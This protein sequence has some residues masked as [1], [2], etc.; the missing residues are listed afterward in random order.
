MKQPLIPHM[1]LKQNKKTYSYKITVFF[2]QITHT[3]LPIR[4]MED[5][6]TQN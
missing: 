5:P 4:R 1:R 3:F 6:T 2:K